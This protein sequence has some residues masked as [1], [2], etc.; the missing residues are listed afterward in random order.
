MTFYRQSLTL[1]DL[2][3][4]DRVFSPRVVKQVDATHPVQKVHTPEHMPQNQPAPH[5]ETAAEHAYHETEQLQAGVTVLRAAQIMHSEVFTLDVRTSIADALTALHARRLRHVPVVSADNKLAGLLSDRDLLLYI[6]GLSQNTDHSVTINI[7]PDTTLPISEIM[8][9]PVLTAST[10]TDV[11]HIAR[12]FVEQ[13]IGAMP[14]VSEGKLTGI[15][16][17]SDILRAVMRH[18]ILEL[19]V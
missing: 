8:K 9:S 11:R 5:H 4:L 10:D 3:P 13:H 1:H 6:G 16:T 12:L 19:W 17:R 2:M 7:R 15:I 18:F 14:I